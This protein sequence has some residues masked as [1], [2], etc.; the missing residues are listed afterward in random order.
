MLRQVTF[1]DVAEAIF[2]KFPEVGSVSP[3]YT[4]SG[5][6]VPGAVVAYIAPGTRPLI[7]Q[8]KD[9]YTVNVFADFWKEV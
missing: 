3:L 8:I 7:N 2:R 4:E 1:D 6:I 9:G 5:K